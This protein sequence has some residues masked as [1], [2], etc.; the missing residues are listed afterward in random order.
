MQIF[1]NRLA[2]L[3]ILIFACNHRS[4]LRPLSPFHGRSPALKAVGD[5]SFAA[6]NGLGPQLKHRIDCLLDGNQLI[7][8]Q[9]AWVVR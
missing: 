7:E 5:A 6:R 3:A 2:L 8:T 9:I 1:L 4:N